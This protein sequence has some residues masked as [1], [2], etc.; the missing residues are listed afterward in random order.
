MAEERSRIARRVAM[1]FKDG[2]I[3]N[4]GIGMPTMAANFVP[5]DVTI[6]L[7]SENGFVGMGPSPAPGQEDLD[8]INAGNQYVTVLPGAAFFDS[9]LSFAII[10]GGHVDV[11]VLGA[12][13]VDELGNIASYII[14]GKMVAGMGGAMDLCTGARRVIIA[15]THCDKRG[16]PKIRRRCTLPLTAVEE[17]DLIVT[18]KAV[19]ERTPDGL[20]L[21]EVAVDSSV[22]EVISLTEAALI[23]PPRVGTF[24]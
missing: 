12:L 3:V 4:L 15:I 10:R 20:L 14:P 18:D 22:E 5:D 17:A 9:A 24:G 8:L 7:Q 19:I 13:E 21:L 16:N 6:V 1:E 2:Q 11:T 23:I